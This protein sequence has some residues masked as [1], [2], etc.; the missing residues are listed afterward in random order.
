[1]SSLPPSQETFITTE[2][3]ASTVAVKYSEVTNAILTEEPLRKSFANDSVDDAYVVQGSADLPN[4]RGGSSP[5]PLRNQR[6]RSK[7]PDNKTFNYSKKL[8]HIKADCRAHKSRNEKAQRADQKGG[9]QEEVNYIGASDK[10]LT[11]DPIY[12]LQKT[13]WNQ[14]FCLKLKNQAHRSQI[15]VCPTM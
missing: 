13:R 4:S 1:M 2:G 5:L 12:Y 11:N 14:K 10:V 7:S 15:R 9:Q 3:N 8:R 6:S